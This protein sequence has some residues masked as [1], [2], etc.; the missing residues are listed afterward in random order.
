MQDTEIIPW[1][2]RSARAIIK[3]GIPFISALAKGM[4]SKIKGISHD[5]LVC[6]AWLGSEL[7]ALGENAIRYSACEILLH[8]IASHLH[9]GFQLD[10]RVLACM[11]LYN[12]TSGKGKT[13]IITILFF[14]V[15]CHF[16]NVEIITILHPVTV[17]WFAMN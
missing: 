13:Y 8:D 10:E 16:I 3:V 5:C 7:A 11:C 15:A 14:L 2:S 9:P 1:S 12:Y 17:E 6:A 4:Q